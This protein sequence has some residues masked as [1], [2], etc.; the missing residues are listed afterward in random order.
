MSV[1]CTSVTV[2]VNVNVKELT[3][4]N[5]SLSR[6]DF[7]SHLIKCL[8][9]RSN[10]ADTS[11]YDSFSEVTSFRQEAIARVYSVDVILLFSHTCIQ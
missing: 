8:R 7:V 5:S 3:S 6:H 9:R 10:E 1:Q 4:V 11:F 2:C